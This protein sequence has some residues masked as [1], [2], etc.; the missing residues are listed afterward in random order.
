MKVFN[1]DRVNTNRQMKQIHLNSV[2]GFY[3]VVRIAG[4]LACL[5]QLL[6]F[7][8]ICFQIF[9]WKLNYSSISRWSMSM[10]CLNIVSLTKFKHT[11]TGKLKGTDFFFKKWLVSR[12]KKSLLWIFEQS[13]Y[14]S[15]VVNGLTLLRVTSWNF[16][17]INLIPLI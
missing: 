9:F 11:L 16:P 7:Q 17:Y 1:P 15:M 2:K 12:Q 5:S 13:I 3:L 8:K 4:C 6:V 14:D 10:Q